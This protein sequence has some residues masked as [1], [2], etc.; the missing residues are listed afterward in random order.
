MQTATTRVKPFHFLIL[1]VFSLTLLFSF[2]ASP[3]LA[4]KPGVTILWGDGSAS[5][6]EGR[7]ERMKAVGLTEARIDWEWRAVEKKQGVYDW[8]AM[9]RLVTLAHKHGITLLPIVHYAPE[10]AL[11]KKKKPSDVYEMAPRPDAFPAYAAFLAASIDRYGPNGNATVTF[12]PIKNWQV[13]NEPN[14][15][16]FWGPS[17][18][19]ADFVDLM[20]TVEKTLG[21]RRGTIRIIHAGLS[22][23]DFSFLWQLWDKD[24]KYG[25]LFDV[26][27]LHP[28]FFN[29]K[30]GVRAVDQIDGDEK[31]Y[32]ALGFIGSSSDHG[33]LSKVFNIQLFLTLKGTPKPIWVTEIGFMAGDKNP[34]AITEEKE[35]ELAK[36]TLAFIDTKLGSEPFGRGARGDIAANVERVYWFTLDDY[37][38]PNDTGNF[39]IYRMDGTARP[40]ADVIQNHT[41]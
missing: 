3:A 41:H 30:G 5:Q 9:D 39:G 2:T 35:A 26:M 1:S 16:Q 7:F 4:H 14:I 15:P 12:T 28:Y 11:P 19:P 22:K 31:E 8:T 10:W 21:P 38:F 24:P 18:N 6:L 34:Y 17:P 13:W 37:G 33:F 40:L 29:P 32:A 36:E 23:A 25:R 27:A 20:T